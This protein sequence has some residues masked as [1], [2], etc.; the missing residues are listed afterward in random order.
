V[1]LFRQDFVIGLVPIAP[2]IINRE[3]FS[4]M[5]ADVRRPEN[6][7]SSALPFLV[8]HVQT[9]RCSEVAETTAVAA[10][11]HERHRAV[12]S[13][14]YAASQSNFTSLACTQMQCA[15]QH[16]YYYSTA[17]I[18]QSASIIHQGFSE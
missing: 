3:C 17:I 1:E 15:N 2:T 14:I 16:Y 11:K 9:A 13:A 10:F 4:Q 6:T 18:G 12:Y 5:I 7:R 8:W